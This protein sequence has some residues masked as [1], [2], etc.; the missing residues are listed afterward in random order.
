MGC[1]I[2]VVNISLSMLLI[3]VCHVV[4]MCFFREKTSSFGVP[5]QITPYYIDMMYTYV[6]VVSCLKSAIQ[7]E[8]EIDIVLGIILAPISPRFPMVD[9]PGMKSQ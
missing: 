4:L 1:C 5:V 7:R 2:H 6:R 3:S 8:C 9:D